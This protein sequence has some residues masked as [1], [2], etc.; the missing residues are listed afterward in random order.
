MIDRLLPLI[1]S[2]LSANGRFYLVVLRANKRTG[3]ARKSTTP[4][5]PHTTEDIAFSIPGFT[6]EIVAGRQAGREALEVLCFT[7]IV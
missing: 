6:M 5:L 2:L 4:P 3:T 7:R 1:P